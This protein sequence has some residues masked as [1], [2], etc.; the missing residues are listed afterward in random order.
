[1]GVAAS[2]DGWAMAGPTAHAMAENDLSL[3]MICVSQDDPWLK[4]RKGGTIAV[5]PSSVKCIGCLMKHAWE[6][7]NEESGSRASCLYRDCYEYPLSD[8]F[9]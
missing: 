3:R 2:F 5:R 1:M 7:R 8:Y 9:Y 6:N 4:E